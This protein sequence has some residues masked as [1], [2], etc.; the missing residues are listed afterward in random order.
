MR[1]VWEEITRNCHVGRVDGIRIVSVERL[2]KHRRDGTKHD[3]KIVTLGDYSTWNHLFEGYD[4][5]NLESTKLAAGARVRLA[6]ATIAS[7]LSGRAR[8]TST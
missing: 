5:R 4:A 6:V 7:R 1:I 2:Q 3:W 8:R